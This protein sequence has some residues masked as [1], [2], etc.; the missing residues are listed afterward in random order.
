MPIRVGVVVRGRTDTSCRIRGATRRGTVGRLSRRTTD[1][2]ARRSAT[3]A[4]PCLCSGRH[5]PVKT[6]GSAPSAPATARVRSGELYAPGSVEVSI[7]IPCLN[8]A[9][10]V[11]GVI[12]DAAGAMSKAGYSAEILVIDSGSTDGSPELASAAGARVFETKGRGYGAACRRGIEEARGEFLVILD[13][14]QSYKCDTLHRFVEPLRA[15]LDMVVGTRRN[16]EIRRGAM[17]AWHRYV[18]EPL[19]TFLLRRRFGVP[20]SDVRCGMRSITRAAARSLPLEANGREL[21]TEMLVRATQAGMQLI[22]VPVTF[23]P[24]KG[25]MSRRRARGSRRATGKALPMSS[26]ERLTKPAVSRAPAATQRR[27]ELP[28]RLTAVVVTKNGGTPFTHLA[29]HLAWQQERYGIDVLVVDS[30]S[31]DRTTTHAR[32]SG[33]TVHTIEPTEFGH[34]RTRNLGAR[35]VDCDVVCF[36]SQDVLP[37]SPDWPAI[38]ARHFANDE[39]VA[40]VCGRQVP[41]SASTAEMWFVSLNYPPTPHRFDPV[42]GG[43]VPGLGRVVF[44]NA[45]AAVRRSTLL[46]IPFVDDIP[47]AEDHVWA[48]MVTERGWSIVYE[49][50]AEALHAH[51]YTLREL[52]R[53]NYLNAQAGALFGLHQKVTFGAGLAHLAREVAYFIRHGHAHRLPWL[54]CYEFVRWLGLQSGERSAWRRK[55]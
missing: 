35:L 5:S 31:T 40:G 21:S 27:Q 32:K 6:P 51:S 41:R 20:L 17:S 45:F 52:Y 39:R 15:G 16:G 33:L 8:E 13:A 25:G 53:R 38:F 54:L 23:Y 48:K 4:L 9:E 30:G 28:L 18:W 10:T 14:D 47:S 22:D 3:R 29:R 36:L 46:E 7:I 50:A 55:V 12:A 24:R 44:S 49:P 37:C 1:E 2:S 19:Q 26:T 42:P 11:Q 34:G 43:H